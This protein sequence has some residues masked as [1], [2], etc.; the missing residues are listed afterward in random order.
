MVQNGATDPWS[1]PANLNPPY[2]PCLRSAILQYNTTIP[3]A[4]TVQYHLEK[5]TSLSYIHYIKQKKTYISYFNPLARNYHNV[6]DLMQYFNIVLHWDYNPGTATRHKDNLLAEDG[7]PH[8]E[9]GY[10]FPTQF[11]ES[12]TETLLQ[13]L[14]GFQALKKLIKK[15]S[16][17]SNNYSY[18]AQSLTRQVHN[19]R[20]FQ[21]SRENYLFQRYRRRDYPAGL[22]GNQLWREAHMCRL[23]PGDPHYPHMLLLRRSFTQEVQLALNALPF[24]D[25]GP[26]QIL[27]D[28]PVYPGSSPDEHDPPFENALALAQDSLVIIKLI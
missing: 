8:E 17:I 14:Q 22:R 15:S 20:T 12:I 10:A 3:V 16:I 11:R 18:H 25:D 7:E 23:I 24:P 4:F 19:S 5:P 26:L 21:Q 13:L 2:M 6:L 28:F 1:F 9:R 27:S